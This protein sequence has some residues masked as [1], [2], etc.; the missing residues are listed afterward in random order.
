MSRRREGGEEREEGGKGREREEGE[1]RTGGGMEIPQEALAQDSI[2][3]CK[4]KY[5]KGT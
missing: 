2:S 1:R 3:G 5:V 4:M